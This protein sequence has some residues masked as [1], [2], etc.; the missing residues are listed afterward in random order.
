MLLVIIGWVLFDKTDFA[1]LGH[2]I[3]VMFSFVPTGWTTLLAGDVSKLFN[4]AFIIPGT[5]FSFPVAGKLHIQE[6]GTVSAIAV[7]LMYIA[8]LAVCIAFIISSSYNPFIYF[9]F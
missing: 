7:N 2:V 4:L 6:K 9:R 3:G 5:L 8:L 1:Q